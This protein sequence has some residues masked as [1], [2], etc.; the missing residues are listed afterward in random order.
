MKNKKIAIFLFAL[1]C[2]TFVIPIIINWLFKFS[3]KHFLLTA[4]WEAGA[5]LT[6][7]G[8]VLSC[9]GTVCLSFATL[10]QNERLHQDLK[11]QT[12]EN[13]WLRNSMFFRP[14]FHVEKVC[15]NSDEVPI[16]SGLWKWK[17]SFL[18]QL[19]IIQI[20][21]RT[22]DNIAA[23]NHRVFCNLY[24]YPEEITE[25]KISKFVAQKAR[26]ITPTE[27]SVIINIHE[28]E[29]DGD[30]I[31]YAVFEYQN[32]LA[33]TYRQLIPILLETNHEI[34]QVSFTIRSLPAALPI[35]K[36]ENSHGE[37]CI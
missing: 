12:K 8:S 1:V 30:G 16:N 24:R 21:L 2:L 26:V 34:H 17:G 31:F 27:D 29:W 13:E 22:A 23:F 5:A 20:T 19:P 28:L 9:I 37:T 15:V 36:D 6:F 7:Y 4:E 11:R 25:P 33:V 32:V 35:R 14:Q 3:S 10:Q 18:N